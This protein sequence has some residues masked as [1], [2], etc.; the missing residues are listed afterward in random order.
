[1]GVVCTTPFTL[2]THSIPMNKCGT[3]SNMEITFEQI[4]KLATTNATVNNCMHLAKHA[5]MS[6]EQTL[7]LIV[8]MLVQENDHIM[9]R[10]TE[11][12]SRSL[13]IGD[14]FDAVKGDNSKS[15]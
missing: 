9:R 1:M 14:I 5:E 8:F 10:A 6:Q 11:V 3:M 12:L 7:C 15:N 2:E 13:Y 4:Q